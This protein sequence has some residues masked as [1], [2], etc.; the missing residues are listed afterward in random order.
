M[1]KHF[2]P[3]PSC[4]SAWLEVGLW[5]IAMIQLSMSNYFGEH[6]LR[7]RYWYWNKKYYTIQGMPVSDNN[8][9]ILTAHEGDG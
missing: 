7:P 8:I 5:F 4:N 2:R 9:Q 6:L 3:Q 1:F